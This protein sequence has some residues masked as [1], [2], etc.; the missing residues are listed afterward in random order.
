ML[1]ISAHHNRKKSLFNR[2]IVG[3]PLDMLSK[4]W[5]SLMAESLI[6]GVNGSGVLHRVAYKTLPDSF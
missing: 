1:Y 4:D 6:L 2:C 5:F 3:A